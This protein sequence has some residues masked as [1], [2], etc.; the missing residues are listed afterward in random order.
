M[1][2][3]LNFDSALLTFL[4]IPEA[5][6]HPFTR[7]TALLSIEC[8][9]MS[10]LYS[11]LYLSFHSLSNIEKGMSWIIVSGSCFLCFERSGID[12]VSKAAT[13]TSTPLYW[14]LWSFLA[15]PTVWLAWS[16]IFFSV[17]LLSFVWTSGDRRAPD[18]RPFTD[19]D[20]MEFLPMSFRVFTPLWPRIILTVVF[21]LGLGGGL[22]VM[23][24]FRNID[25][26]KLKRTS[27]RLR[28]RSRESSSDSGSSVEWV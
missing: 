15:L 14:N 2:W 22:L 18:L 1:K 13:Q 28:S 6:L 25:A 11:A 23:K 8:A 17:S 9:F 3:Y 21:T 24:A 7:L 19:D 16:S 10:L 4:Q 26:N 12:L 5:G 20:T 27:P